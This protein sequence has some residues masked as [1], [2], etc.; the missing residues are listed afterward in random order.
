MR[1]SGGL[2]FSALSTRLPIARSSASGSPRTSVGRKS[3]SYRSPGARPAARAATRSATRSSRTS[4]MWYEACPS[5][6]SSTRS[7]I[8]TRSSPASASAAA[9][10]AGTLGSSGRS[11]SSSRLVI[12]LVSG[13]RSSCEAS[14]TSRRCE[15][16]DSSSAAVIAANACPSRLISSWPG[17]SIGALRSP[18]ALIRSIGTR[19][20]ADRAQHPARGQSGP[21]AP[22]RPPPGYLTP[23]AADQVTVTGRLGR[24]PGATAF[25]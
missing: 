5:R 21:S 14:A 19:C 6:A 20:P 13:V 23:S 16:A 2:H 4:S 1:P 18:V 25:T 22:I 3:S 15:P 8:S 7:L 12:R 9:A 10:S 17:V 11:A 24:S